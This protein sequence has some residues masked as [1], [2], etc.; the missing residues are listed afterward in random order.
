MGSSE[1]YRVVEALPGVADTL[2]VDTGRLGQEGRLWLF[3]QTAEGAEL[4]DDL[5]RAIR[6]T[7]RTQVS[8]RHVPDRIV[9]VAE[10]PYTL[11]GK[12]IEV[13]IKRI[14]TGDATPEAAVS[15]DS[16]R[17]PSALQVFVEYAGRA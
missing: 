1:F 6:T 3:V 11:S 5:L 17:N 7:L 16:L 4:D 10:I 15:A 14:L 13:P 8:P 2:V 12:K 9:H